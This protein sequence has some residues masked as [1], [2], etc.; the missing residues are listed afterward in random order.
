MIALPHQVEGSLK[1]GKYEFH[2]VRWGDQ[3]NRIVLLHSM[4]MDAHSMDLLAESLSSGH[5]VL[6][7]TI[8]GHGDS[9]VPSEPVTLQDHAEMLLECARSLEHTPFTLV[10]HSVGGRLG[11]ILAAEHP[12]DVKGLVL[13][14]IAPPD[15]TP[16]AWRQRTAPI[17]RSRE[18][19][20]AHLKERYPRFA[21]EYIENRLR[22]GFTEQPDGSLAPKPAGNDFMRGMSTDLW[23]YVERIRVPT[24]LVK[25][26]DSALVTP[27][28]HARM[29]E[30]IP[31]FASVTILGATHMVPQE[32]PEEFEETVRSFISKI[33]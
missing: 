4:G 15:T 13:V 5:R 32:K 1:V 31:E 22:Y 17:L 14:D 2:Y 10:G 3:G 6:A 19:A 11:M 9:T 28:K 25:G 8:L 30:S 24:L 20:L 33:S 27:E 29:R 12:S 16:R 23:P 21:P 7:L 26:A 18:E